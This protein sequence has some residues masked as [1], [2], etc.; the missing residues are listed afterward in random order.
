MQ[1][2]LLGKGTEPSPPAA[3][4]AVNMEALGLPG[5]RGGKDPLQCRR[6]RR[7]GFQPRV[8]RIPRRRERQ[9]PPG[10]LPGES[11]GQRSLVGYSP[12]GHRVSDTTE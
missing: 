10:S 12:R 9:L 3:P 1:W 11:H 8:G 2:S 6:R 4:L 5:G 7:H